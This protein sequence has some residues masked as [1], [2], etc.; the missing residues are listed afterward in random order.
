MLKNYINYR[1]DKIKICYQKN[2]ELGI[3]N[4]K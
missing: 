4:K 1:N 2:K 3:N